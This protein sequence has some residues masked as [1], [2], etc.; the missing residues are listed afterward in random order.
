M[1]R[2]LTILCLLFLLS[3]EKQYCWNCSIK[4]R[5]VNADNVVINWYKYSFEICDQTQT[6]IHQF[7]KENTIIVDTVRMIGSFIECQKQ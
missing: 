7:E 3:C 1:K 2:I 4:E 5:Y 6:E